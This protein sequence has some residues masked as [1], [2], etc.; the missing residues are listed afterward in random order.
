[1]TAVYAIA[2]VVGLLALIAWIAATG[3]A[4]SV[5]QWERIDPEQ[6]FGSRG[7]LALAATLGFGL[8]GMS[9]TFAGSHAGSAFAAALI[10]SALVTLSARLL[11]PP[12]PHG[13]AG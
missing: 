12:S 10:G 13:S 6:R 9:G 2:V 3:I 4:S 11:G 1:M 8:G 7:R 5:E